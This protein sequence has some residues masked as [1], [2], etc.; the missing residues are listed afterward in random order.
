MALILA[1]LLLAAWLNRELRLSVSSSVDEESVPGGGVVRPNDLCVSA[2]S[3]LDVCLGWIL[4]GD[5][6][7]LM[8]NGMKRT[9]LKFLAHF[10]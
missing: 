9:L 6:K 5:F 2:S 7:K 4:Q 10:R 8:E 1:L 3:P